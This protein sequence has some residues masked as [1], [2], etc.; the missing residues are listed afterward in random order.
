MSEADE[1]R[2]GNYTHT[3]TY[4]YTPFDQYYKSM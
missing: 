1:S 2:N 4:A 3:N